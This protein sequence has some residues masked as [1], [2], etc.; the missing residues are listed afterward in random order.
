MEN[1]FVITKEQLEERK[2]VGIENFVV[3]HFSSDIHN[4]FR[5]LTNQ[6]DNAKSCSI[7]YDFQIP[8]EY[9]RYYV[10]EHLKSYFQS[11]GYSVHEMIQHIQSTRV[12]LQIC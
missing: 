9:N 7:E 2:R 10:V 6:A 12:V 3:T 8:D 11:Y 4:I 1:N 5:T